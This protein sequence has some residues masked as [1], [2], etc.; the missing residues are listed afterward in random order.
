MS[1]I[2]AR[3]K[4]ARGIGKATLDLQVCILSVINSIGGTWTVRQIFYA[5]SVAG[6]VEKTEAGY[7]KVQRQV[8][9]MRRTGLIKYSTI[10]DNTRWVRQVATF[11]SLTDW[12]QESLRTLRID[13]WRDADERVE[14]WLEKDALAGVVSP[15][16][17]E[18]HVPLFVTRGYASESFAYEA[19]Q[20]ANADGRNFRIVYMGDFDASGVQMSRD[21]EHRLRGFLEHDVQ[22]RFDRIAVT[23]EQIIEWN[24]P[25]RPNKDTDTRHAAFVEEFGGMEATELDAIPPNRLQELVEKSIIDMIDIDQLRRIEVEEAEAQKVAAQFAERLVAAA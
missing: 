12:V 14:V 24:L 15:I 18:W 16:T 13:F 11:H 4:K 20:S 1:Q 9:E 23:P 21:L 2:G 7:R 10:A 5:T 6:G 3:T 22:L 8:L 25:S 19:A 17:R